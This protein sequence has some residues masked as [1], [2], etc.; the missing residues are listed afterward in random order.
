[1][2]KTLQ[3]VNININGL[4]CALVA[5]KGHIHC[6]LNNKHKNKVVCIEERERERERERRE[7]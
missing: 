2:E 5:I 7:R 1:M 3:Y 6:S 4:E